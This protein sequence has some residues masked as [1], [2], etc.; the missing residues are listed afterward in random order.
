MKCGE[1]SNYMSSIGRCKFCHYEPTYVRNIFVDF[2]FDNIYHR[3]CR[4]LKKHL[5]DGGFPVD[6]L[7]RSS[8]GNKTYYNLEFNLKKDEWDF[9]KT[10]DLKIASFLGIEGVGLVD[11]HIQNDGVIHEVLLINE[12]ELNDKYLK[13]GNLVF[14]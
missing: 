7:S 13:D 10:N 4:Q 14:E 1:C 9:I 6:K 5:D 8:V 3:T 12:K 11:F 2:D